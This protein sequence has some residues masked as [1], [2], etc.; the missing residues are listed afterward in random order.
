MLATAFY[1]NTPIGAI[2]YDVPFKVPPGAS[3]TPRLPIDWSLGSI[4]HDVVKKA[5]GGNLKVEAEAKV[6]V[7]VGKWREKVWFKGKG[8]GARVNL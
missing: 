5:L 4:G 8:I 7:R 6:G 2:E 1:N 3:D